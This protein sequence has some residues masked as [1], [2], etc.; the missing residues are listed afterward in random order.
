MHPRARRLGAVGLALLLAAALN[1]PSLDLGLVADDVAQR[2]HVL[3]QLSG[4]DARGQPWEMFGYRTTPPEVAFA[5]W[6][7][8]T[9][10]WTSPELQVA[11]FRPL[12]AATHFADYA[13]W[14][15][16]TVAMHAHNVAWYLALLVALGALYRRLL[17]AGSAAA[18][19]LLL[20]AVDEAHVHA[21]SWIA[22]RNTVITA[23]FVALTLDA[24]VAW[25]R[26]AVRTGSVLAP[27]WLVLAN[28]SS[29]GGIATL[30]YL[31]AYASFVD[32]GTLRQRVASLLPAIAVSAAHHGASRAI[33]YG[34]TGS[35]LYLDPLHAPAAFLAQLPERFVRML[36]EQFSLPAMVL[37][38][39]PE[40]SHGVI[41]AGAYTMLAV[42]LVVACLQARRDPIVRFLLAGTLLSVVPMC[43]IAIDVSPRLLLV[44]GIGAF[45]MIGR[46]VAAALAAG[47]ASLPARAGAAA[48]LA[49]HGLLAAVACPAVVQQGRLERRY[50]ERGAAS[51]ASLVRADDDAVA[52]LETPHTFMTLI[53]AADYAQQRGAKPVFVVGASVDPV[54]IR[55]RDAHGE[56]RL[57]LEAEGGYLREP[58]S[59]LV[60]SAA[61]PFAAGATFALARVI[62]TVETLTADRRPARI[63]V[64]ATSG[65]RIAWLLWS[66]DHERYERLEPATLPATL[67]LR[68]R[69]PRPG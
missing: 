34:V 9:P 43:T 57:V 50:L 47:A 29:E 36:C 52:I 59:L 54:R 31:V 33:G 18:S 46:M 37:R 58:W 65:S 42:I 23:L 51:L 30:A 39:A 53:N 6:L 45:A 11:M 60:R 15:A 16:S 32:R 44:P 5:A 26:D 61:E 62:V 22:S 10:W 66:S 28:A 8:A 7:G 1:A 19:A 49:V 2:A 35:G 21:V 56:L 27:C 48:L 17:G 63:R 4:H 68:P 67:L 69:A 3:A 13:L 55:R 40:A 12:A 14:P 24:H 41:E 20:Y 25:R 64:Q 38:Y